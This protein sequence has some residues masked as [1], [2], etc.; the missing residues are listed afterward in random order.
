MVDVDVIAEPTDATAAIGPGGDPA[1]HRRGGQLGE[2]I[3]VVGGADGDEAL[4]VDAV[5]REGVEVDVQVGGAAEALDVGDG[6][7]VAEGEAE[8]GGAAAEIGVELRGEDP[9]Q[10]SEERAVI[11]DAE[12]EFEGQREQT[13]SSADIVHRSSAL[14]RDPGPASAVR[15]FDYPDRELGFRVGALPASP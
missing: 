4:E 7:G 12:P 8:G 6:V 10:L 13:E 1:L 11:G 2:E 15:P 3:V 9:Q 5:E 14:D